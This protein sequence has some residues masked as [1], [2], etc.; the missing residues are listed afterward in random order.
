VQH[1]DAAFLISPRLATRSPS[2]S[3]SSPSAQPA[4]ASSPPS[5][6]SVLAPPRP[7][8][9]DLAV[10]HGQLVEEPTPPPEL[11]HVERRAL[12]DFN[13]HAGATDPPKKA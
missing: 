5:P 10:V 9:E 4:K 11:D 6:S 12:F 8:A 7:A 1:I 3:P 13:W 2:S